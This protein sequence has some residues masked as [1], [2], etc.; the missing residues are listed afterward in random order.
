MRSVRQKN[1]NHELQCK[2]LTH[3]LQRE[4]ACKKLEKRSPAIPCTWPSTDC[5]VAADNARPVSSLT[6]S[7]LFLH[8]QM[9]L[10]H[11]TC[12]TAVRAYVAKKKVDWIWLTLH[13]PCD[14]VTGYRVHHI[15]AP[16][17]TMHTCRLGQQAKGGTRNCL[18]DDACAK[19][20]EMEASRVTTGAIQ[21]CTHHR[22]TYVKCRIA[23]QLQSVR[24]DEA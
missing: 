8:A 22:L 5:T 24:R 11:P 4:M 14:K 10:H 19:T 6:Y 13:V 16:T 3:F 7:C 1:S 17:S 23:V 15:R 20:T 12:N 18:W 2:R 9:Q 21:L